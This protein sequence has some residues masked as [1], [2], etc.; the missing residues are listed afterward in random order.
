MAKLKNPRH[1][2]FAQE[3][4]LKGNAT[5]AYRL[6]YKTKSQTDATIYSAASH[7]L[8]EPK[9]STRVAELQARASQVAEE[10]FEINAE[11]VLKHLHDVV[12]MKISDILQD[13]GRVKPISLWPDVWQ[14][15]IQG[16]DVVEMVGKDEEPA[17]II[18]KLRL[19]DRAKYL[20]MLGKHVQVQAFKD[21]VEHEAGRS[22]TDLLAEIRA[23]E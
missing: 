21:R 10:K 11:Y 8:K 15:T 9:V 14:Q 12:E 22:L 2:T 18:R 5:A 3:Y 6:A 16:L 20:D 19:P 13:N 23:S 17:A 4:V 7:L 1:E